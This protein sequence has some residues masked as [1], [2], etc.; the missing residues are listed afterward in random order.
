MFLD[1]N[2][3]WAADFRKPKIFKIGLSYRKIN[4]FLNRTFLSIVSAL[5]FFKSE[6]EKSD[7]GH[8]SAAW[9][10]DFKKPKILKI[11]S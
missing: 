5:L 1:T 7:L 9:A 3:I 2:R 6:I 11:R 8:F 10:T 4:D